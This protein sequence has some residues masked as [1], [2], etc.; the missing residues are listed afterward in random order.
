MSKRN[1]EAVYPLSP[2]QQ[3]MLFHSLY[4]PGSGVYV[5]QVNCDMRGGLD[6]TTFERAW[7]RVL[8]RHPVLRTSFAW[9]SLDKTLQVVHRQVALPLE[10]HDWRGLSQVEQE[11]RLGTFLREDRRQ[12]FDLARAPLM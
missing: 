4:A 6:V 8:A 11:T 3:G 7:R 10:Q 12:G 1:I 2:M 9:K 5:E